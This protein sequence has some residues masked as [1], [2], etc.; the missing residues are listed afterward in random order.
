AFAC[1]LIVAADDARFIEVFIRRALVP[2]AGGAYLLTRMIGPHRAKQLFFFGEDVSAEQAL[3]LGMVNK[4]VP[5]AELLPAALEWAGRLASGP[6][7]TFALTKSLVNRSLDLDRASS[8]EL[9]A[10]AQDQNMMTHDGPEGVRS[11]VE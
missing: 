5:T 11:F 2:D 9:E 8:F 10:N 1:D 4:V 3:A 7:R 6:T